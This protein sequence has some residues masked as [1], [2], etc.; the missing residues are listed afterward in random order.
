MSFYRE[1]FPN[2]TVLPKMHLMEEH[3]VPFIRKWNVGFGIMGEQ[4][5]E[6]IHACFNGIERDYACKIHSRVDRLKS[7]VQQNHLKVSP[8]NVSLL[9]PIKKRKID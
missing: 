2:A 1:T 6:S 9:P 4:G 7:V 3:M 8:Q 5:A